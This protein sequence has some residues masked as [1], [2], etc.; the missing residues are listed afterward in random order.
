[1]IIDTKLVNKKSSLYSFFLTIILFFYILLVDNIV[2]SLIVGVILIYMAY[3]PPEPKPS[4]NSAFL[5]GPL[6]PKA[7][8]SIF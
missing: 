1:M 5:S 7:K 8:S 4:Q 2:F 3:F 6:G